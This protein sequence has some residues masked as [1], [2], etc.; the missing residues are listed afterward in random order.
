[1][2]DIEQPDEEFL[3]VFMTQPAMITAFKEWVVNQGWHLQGPIK[4]SEDDTPTHF[5]QPLPSEEALTAYLQQSME[6][7][8]KRKDSDKT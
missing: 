5:L 3:Q 2:S 4:F 6:D 1:M 7:W 8:M